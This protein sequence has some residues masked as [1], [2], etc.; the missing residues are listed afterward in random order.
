[1]RFVLY[2]QTEVLQAVLFCQ[3]IHQDQ[4]IRIL[5]DTKFAMPPKKKK[6]HETDDED[7]F[8]FDHQTP[9]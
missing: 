5:I 3:V 8:F 6:L 7:D 1:M 9:T 2:F 4:S